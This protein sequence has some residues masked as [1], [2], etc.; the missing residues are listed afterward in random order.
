VCAERGPFD[1][2][3]W[4]TDTKYTVQGSCASVG[5]GVFYETSYKNY[6]KDATKEEV[7]LYSAL[8]PQPIN[9]GH[10]FCNQVWGTIAEVKSYVET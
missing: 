1:E 10:S 2:E 9:P 8:V 4:Q 5:F 3:Y 7:W 6:L